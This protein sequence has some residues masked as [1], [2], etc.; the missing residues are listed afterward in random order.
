MWTKLKNTYQSRGPARKATLLKKLTQHKMGND[1]EVR[2]HLDRFFDA[3]DKLDSMNVDINPDLLDI[4]LLHSLPTRYENFRCA[5]EARDELPTPEVLRVKILEESET[6]K[7]EAN[8][9]VG[10]LWARGT[11]KPQSYKKQNEKPKRAEPSKEFKIK[12]H[13]CRQAGHI[14]KNRPDKT[15][16]ETSNACF[17]VGACMNEQWCLDSGATSYLCKDIERFVN[18]DQEHV[19]KLSLAKG[20]KTDISAIGKVTFGAGNGRRVTNLTLQDIGYISMTSS[21]TYSN[22]IPKV[23][24]QCHA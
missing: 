7:G 12:C 16:T 14:S 17:Q 5:I 23:M 8:N 11:R 1:E 24:F 13:R 18:I 10:A 3:V 2:E 20:N 19:R 6:R 21:M 15:S 22:Y 9:V 4:L